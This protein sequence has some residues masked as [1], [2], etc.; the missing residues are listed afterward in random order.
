MLARR[1]RQHACG[2]A[3]RLVTERASQTCGADR[4]CIE[5]HLTEVVELLPPEV[6]VRRDIASSSRAQHAMARRC[7]RRGGRDRGA[8]RQTWARP[9]SAAV[10][11]E[12]ERCRKV[13]GQHGASFTASLAGSGSRHALSVVSCPVTVGTH[14]RPSPR[15]RRDRV[16]VPA[17]GYGRRS[18]LRASWRKA[19]IGVLTRPDPRSA[20]SRMT[21]RVTAARRQPRSGSSPA[22][23]VAKQMH[24]APCSGWEAPS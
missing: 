2:R 7:A 21:S 10:T 19:R 16:G 4:Q 1:A 15:P 20:D 3:E 13:V 14:H 12:R 6:I 24:R 18:D 8:Q 5:P 17:G 23:P 22:R 9:R 11:C